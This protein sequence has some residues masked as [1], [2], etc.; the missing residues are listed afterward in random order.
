MMSCFR[1]RGWPRP[2]ASVIL[3]IIIKPVR[4]LRLFGPAWAKDENYRCNF[5]TCDLKSLTDGKDATAWLSVSGF[6]TLLAPELRR[7]DSGSGLFQSNDIIGLL[8][9]KL[10][11]DMPIP[12]F[13]LEFS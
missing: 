7:L 5:Y 8:G 2:G 10:I 12:A 1:L 3:S 9:R 13:R 6:L 4:L 11:I